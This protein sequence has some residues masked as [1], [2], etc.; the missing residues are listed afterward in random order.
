MINLKVG[1]TES[2]LFVT[3]KRLA[4]NKKGLNLIYNHRKI[5][6]TESYKYLGSQVNQNLN[7]NFDATYKKAF[8]RTRLIYKLKSCLADDVVQSI[9]TMMI[10]P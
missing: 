7:L 6:S 8:A 3:M 4:Q 1:K 5:N 2:I 9:Y 10:L